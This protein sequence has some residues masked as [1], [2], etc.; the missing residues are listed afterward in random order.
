VGQL[1]TQPGDG[2]RW[3]RAPRHAAARA[4]H[5]SGH[6]V[7]MGWILIVMV[8]F[9][10]AVGVLFPFLVDPLV[11]AAP[12]RMTAY[13]LLCVLAG[14]FVAAFAY[15][16][17]RFTL[18]RANLVLVRLAAYDSLTGLANRRQFVR[19]LGAELIRADRTGQTLGLVIV[20]LDTFKRIN[21]EHGHL[22]GDD[23]LVAVA[24][25]MQASVRPFDT[26]CRIGGEEFAL[27]LPQT[28]RDAA[29][30]VAERLR[31]LVALSGHDGLPGITVSCGVAT[32]PAD[33]VSLNSLIKAAD[34]AMYEAKRAGRNRVV[35][36]PPR[37]GLGLRRVQ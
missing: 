13:R 15:S 17:A 16:V 37:T 33:A 1:R 28:D 36:C 5:L 30:A 20:D 34:D 27:V 22:V 23:A 21:D 9:G 12:G 6:D 8:A 18:Y 31:S 7:A 2:R 35:A 26:V 29:V 10:A 11:E 4:T 14:L 32:Y 25:D 19:A 3:W 24:R